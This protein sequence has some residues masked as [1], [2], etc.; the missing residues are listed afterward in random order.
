MTRGWAKPLLG[1]VET[2]RV[3]PPELT[4]VC[5]RARGGG[6]ASV[7]PRTH[8]PISRSPP[9]HLGLGAGV[10]RWVRF[11]GSRGGLVSTVVPVALAK[12][13]SSSE[14]PPQRFEVTSP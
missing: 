1:L 11:L 12:V 7:A 9:P 6:G 4:S 5:G 10:P 14:A 3:P 8:A 13:P 2:P